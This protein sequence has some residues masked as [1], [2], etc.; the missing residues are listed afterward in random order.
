MGHGR[1]SKASTCGTLNVV[2][3]HPSILTLLNIPI[4]QVSSRTTTSHQELGEGYKTVPPTRNEAFREQ[5]AGVKVGYGGHLPGSQNHFGSAHQGGV[6]LHDAPPQ[7]FQS[8]PRYEPTAA[9][10]RRNTFQPAWQLAQAEATQRQFHDVH[11]VERV[12]PFGVST[13]EEQRRDDSARFLTE[14]SRTGPRVQSR[15]GP[16]SPDSVM[17]RDDFGHAPPTPHRFEVRARCACPDRV[18]PL[19]ALAITPQVRGHNS[20]LLADPSHLIPSDPI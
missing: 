19:S 17:A 16:P 3:P 20:C 7:V 11:K 12:A 8:A 15:R 2:L 9:E 10:I 5:V 1:L 6:P 14:S 13:G 4:R 18:S